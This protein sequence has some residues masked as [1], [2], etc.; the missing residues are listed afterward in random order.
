[1]AYA[2]SRGVLH[3]DL[4]P[5]N[6]MLGAVRRDPGRRL[7]PGQGRRTRPTAPRPSRRPGADP[8]DV[9]GRPSS[10]TLFGSAVGTP[11]FM[12][13][14]QAA[15]RL[16]QLGPA[17]DIYSLGATLYAI[18]TGEPPFHEPTARRRCSTRSARATSRR[19]A[20]VNRERPPALEAICLKAMALR[21]E[22]RYASA[23]DLA[24]DIEHW[25]ADEPVSAYREPVLARL[26]RW[27]QRHKTAVAAA[28]ALLVT[29]VVSL[30]GRHRP[31]PAASRR[32]TEGNYRLARRAVDEMLTQ[33]GEVDLADVPQMEP[34][35]ARMLREAKAF[36]EQLRRAKRGDPAPP[37][38]SP[39][40]GLRL[41]DIEAC[42]ATSRPCP[43]TTIRRGAPQPA[44]P[45]PGRP[46]AR[47]DLARALHARGLLRR[48][49]NRLTTPSAT[50]PRRSGLRR[51]WPA[52][53]RPTRPPARPD[54][55]PLPP[56]R[57]STTAGAGPGTRRKEYAEAIAA[58]Q[59]ARRRARRQPRRPPPARPVH[60]Q[61]RQ[62]RDPR[63]ADPRR[64]EGP[65]REALAIQQDVV[66][67][68]PVT[69]FYRYELAK[70]HGNLRIALGAEG[71][72]KEA[73]E[74]AVD[75]VALS[76]PARRRLPARARLPQQARRPPDR[77]SAT[78]GPTRSSTTR[79]REDLDEAVALAR[80]LVRE[81][82]D[83][84]DYQSILAAALVNRAT[85]RERTG[86]DHDAEADLIE[87][88]DTLGRSPPRPEPDRRG[89]VRP[90]HRLLQP[91]E[92][93]LPA[94]RST[95]RSPTSTRPSNFTSGPRRSAAPARARPRALGRPRGSSST[96]SSEAPRE[97]GYAR[98]ADV[99]ERLPAL[100]PDHAR[101]VPRRRPD[102]RLP[103]QRRRTGRRARPRRDERR[104][105]AAR[106]LKVTP[107]GRAA[108]VCS[109]PRSSTTR[110][111]S[112]VRELFPEDFRELARRAVKEA[113]RV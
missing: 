9:G 89:P 101:L 29:A 26:A 20:Q 70:T 51:T 19:P 13:P 69:A 53:S 71:D 49:L 44:R 47:D 95:R 16:D 85:L 110:Y 60:Q 45:D 10:R 52:S 2:H 34:V 22:D 96:C 103:L 11:Q 54:R 112:K 8:A 25:L 68:D 23:R 102:A 66:K 58:R 74:H 84:R 88:R 55:H 56:R 78:C 35:R 111:Y 63:P 82:A 1:M 42:S 108:G 21:P 75:D 81:H 18:L 105:Y 41:G 73:E 72:L 67:R 92:G 32:R 107:R 33:L 93:P 39:S 104:G 100:R 14:E 97:V 79:P 43:V 37:A 86:N 91:G 106:A 61:P 80:R 48:K 76:A 38:T 15:G 27:A 57:A 113:D 77:T 30:G 40:P 64:G 28:A 50:C 62:P 7:G 3:R 17:S 98:C 36:Y 99:C 65:L 5:A 4:K 59:G 90:R 12:S 87:A 6:I 24:D 94:G 31:D 83:H 109:T 46:P